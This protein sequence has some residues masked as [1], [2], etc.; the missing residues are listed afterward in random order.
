MTALAAFAIS[1]SLVVDDVHAEECRAADLRLVPFDDFAGL[2]RSHSARE[3][4]ETSGF[5][6]NFSNLNVR[7]ILEGGDDPSL[8]VGLNLSGIDFTCA[9]LAGV[10]LSGAR[11]IETILVG[12]TL[13]SAILR[14]VLASRADLSRARLIGATFDAN[15]S[16]TQADL[17]GANLSGAVLDGVS[18]IGATLSNAILVDTRIE[19]ADLSSVDVAG[20]L[21][22]PR[23]E[24]QPDALGRM[25]GMSDLQ[26]SFCAVRRS[27]L[28]PSE[29]SS[30]AARPDLAALE[31]LRNSFD[32]GGDSGAVR[33]VAHAIEKA[34]T[35]HAWASVQAGRGG[36]IPYAVYRTVWHD[37]FVDHGLGMVRSTMYLLTSV[38]V[39][40]LFY[41]MLHQRNKRRSLGG[42][43]WR[44]RSDVHHVDPYNQIQAGNADDL[45][46]DTS[47]RGASWAAIC[48][49]L[50]AT[51]RVGFE[52]WSLLTVAKK[53]LPFRR[54]AS[55]VG[56]PRWIGGIQTV[57][58]TSLIAV[59]AYY[60]VL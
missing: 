10:D 24:L 34:R 11:L 25:T 40:A 19:D 17:N 6:P 33:E 22:S 53:Y 4:E 26:T 42:L 15:S 43:F 59:L 35:D 3:M 12:A 45:W 57:F 1:L 46:A 28:D 37:A 47:L 30:I 32:D 14:G 55:A 31:R 48:Y 7:V 13:D 50:I 29:C 54:L 8:L 38:L 51:T 41:F 20:A 58:V 49:S 23:G 36:A 60:A 39:F 18:M 27:Q 16:L 52:R 21:W 9:N 44:A 5:G 56:W 2:V